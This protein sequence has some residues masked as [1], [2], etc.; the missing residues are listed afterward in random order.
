M[1]PNLS[2]TTK[3]KILVYGYGNP[4][5]EDD[6]L[7]PALAVLIE[8]W[9]KE[10]AI[11]NIDALSAYQLSIED[12]E[13]VADRDLVIFC[14]SSTEEIDS[15]KLSPLKP[16][17]KVEFSMHSI[18]PSFVLYL[19]KEIHGTTPEAYI[20]HIKGYD[21]EIKEGLTINAG[22]N[23]DKAFEELTNFLNRKLSSHS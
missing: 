17:P 9:V 6:G 3:H 1:S 16:S 23:L 4:G 8:T 19:C 12:S 22:K 13:E 15:Y 5:R 18:S 11:D 2:V 20:M 10:N 7:G 14:D 21:Y